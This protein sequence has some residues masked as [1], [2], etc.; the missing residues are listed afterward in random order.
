MPNIQTFAQLNCFDV[1]EVEHI[2][3]G[4]SLPLGNSYTI[5]HFVSALFECE[6]G[7]AVVDLLYWHGIALDDLVSFEYNGSYGLHRDSW[8]MCDLM[9][10]IRPEYNKFY[11]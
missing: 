3:T 5:E 4:F 7:L 1:G 11:A 10:F 8:A 9:D 6:E 2:I